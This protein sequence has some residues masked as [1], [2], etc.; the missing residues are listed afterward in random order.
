MIAIHHREGSFSNNWIEYCQKNDIEYK[1]VDC[2][3]TTIVSDLDECNTLM[4]HWHHSDYKAS[5]FARELTIS[6][7]TSG[8]KVFPCRNTGWHFDDKVG[9]KY[10]FESLNI[11]F[12]NSHVFYEK[13]EAL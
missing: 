7:E 5:L 1:L 13:S 11:P 2:Y 12:I 6:L 4:W 3:S 9:Q 8:K 10:L